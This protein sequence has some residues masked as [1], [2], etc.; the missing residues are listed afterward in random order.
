[1]IVVLEAPPD[2]NLALIIYNDP[3]GQLS[4]YGH[5]GS[6]SSGVGNHKVCL[7]DPVG[8]HSLDNFGSPDASWPEVGMDLSEE[9]KI[10]LRFLNDK[11]RTVIERH[12]WH[13]LPIKTEI[14][15][16]GHII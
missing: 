3:V 13:D 12:L 11:R 8:C 4:S 10:L 9:P 1:M 16:Y 14:A 5:S 6:T 7:D 2:P 15:L